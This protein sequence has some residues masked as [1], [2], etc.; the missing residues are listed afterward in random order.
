[1][2]APRVRKDRGVD[3][4]GLQ[5]V[6]ET[7]HELRGRSESTVG[8][9]RISHP[10]RV[11]DASTGTTK[12]DLV[13]YYEWIA[14]RM[15]PHLAERPVALVRATDGIGGE[16]FFQ[17]HANKLVLPHVTQHKELDPDPSLAWDK[18]IEAAQLTRELLG[19]L[20]HTTSGDQWNV[21]NLHE[22]LDALKRDPWDGYA[23]CRQRI[24]VAMRKR[25]GIG[26]PPC[27]PISMTLSGGNP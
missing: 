18:M 25:L 17:K 16:Q 5:S 2:T 22:R 9:V 27:A 20:G 6:Q 11:I 4:S 15:L 23:K 3:L 8:N 19:E 14:P 12:L 1:M 7:S 24:T 21:G 26:C 10:E 13:R